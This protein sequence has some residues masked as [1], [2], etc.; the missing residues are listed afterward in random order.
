V[1]KEKIRLWLE[2]R[3]LVKH[4]HILKFKDCDLGF[5]PEGA[6]TGMWN[7]YYRCDCGKE[8]MVKKEGFIYGFEEG[9]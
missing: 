5:A 3:G 4:K 7:I 8:I 6:L 2:K 1:T 9:R